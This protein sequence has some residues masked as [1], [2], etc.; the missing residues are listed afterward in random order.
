MLRRSKASAGAIYLNKAERIERI[1]AAAAVAQRR[2]PS[3]R[4][5][6]LF[7]SLVNGIAVPK[8]DADLLV[9]VDSSPFGNPRDRIPEMLRAFAPLPCPLDLFIWTTSELERESKSPFAL[10]A[11]SGGIDVL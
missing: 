1:R 6:I 4:R 3:I 10:A 8:S 2:Q 11:L 7:G 5:V 9:I